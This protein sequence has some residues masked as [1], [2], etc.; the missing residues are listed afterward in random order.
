MYSQ[1]EKDN[2]AMK[3][4]AIEKFEKKCPPGYELINN[5]C[6]KKGA[7]NSIGAKIGVGAGIAGA[8]GVGVSMIS[9]AIKNKKEKKQKLADKELLAGGKKNK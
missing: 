9:D 2:M 3:N 1:D 8:I 5:D 7:L 6:V 4:S